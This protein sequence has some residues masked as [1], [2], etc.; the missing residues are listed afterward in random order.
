[1]V[2]WAASNTRHKVCPEFLSWVFSFLGGLSDI[3]VL[4]SI[5]LDNAASYRPSA[6]FHTREKLAWAET[7]AERS[8]ETIPDC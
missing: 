3:V 2:V 7:G 4:R 6:E 1:L 5:M 8:F